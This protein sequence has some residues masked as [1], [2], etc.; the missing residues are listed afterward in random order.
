MPRDFS[1][2]KPIFSSLKGF[3][4]RQEKKV[5]RG[6][7]KELSLLNLCGDKLRAAPY[8]ARLEDGSGLAVLPGRLQRDVTFGVAVEH[9]EKIVVGTAHDDAEGQR[10]R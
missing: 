10:N 4:R 2:T 1:E 9:S 8:L 5:L 6:I 7:K 3:T